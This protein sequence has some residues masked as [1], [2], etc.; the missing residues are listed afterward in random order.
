MPPA[1]SG[2][3]SSTASAA[4][5]SARSVATAGGATSSARSGL[6]FGMWSSDSNTVT[7]VAPEA[8]CCTA[9]TRAVLEEASLRLPEMARILTPVTT[10]G[11]V[12]FFR[13]PCSGMTGGPGPKMRRHMARC[14]RCGATVESKHPWDVVTCECGSLT[15]SGGTVR[16]HVS[17]TASAGGGW[18][19]LSEYDHDDEGVPRQGTA[20]LFRRRRGTRRRKS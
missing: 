18:S 4:W 9:R 7:D 13:L 6:K 11:S 1:Y 10:A 8:A 20:R 16:P 2:V 19:D 15:I 14:D 3:A 5:S 12:A 17:W